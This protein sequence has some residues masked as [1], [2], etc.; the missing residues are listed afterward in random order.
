LTTITFID[1]EGG[2]HDV[3]ADNGTSVMEV[4]VKHGIAGIYAECGGT[5]SCATCHVYVDDAWREATGAPDD[6]E[7]GMLDA[8][9]DR[10]PNSRLCCQINIGPELEGLVVEVADNNL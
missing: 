7:D 5:C 9:I 3:D 6:L 4:A 1:R 10:R 8:A 2:R